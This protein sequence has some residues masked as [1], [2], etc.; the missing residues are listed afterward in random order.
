MARNT[1]IDDCRP[2]QPPCEKSGT[3]PGCS[4]SVNLSGGASDVKSDCEESV[5][6][7]CKK[8]LEDCVKRCQEKILQKLDDDLEDANKEF[9]KNVQKTSSDY[10]RCQKTEKYE[11]K[12]AEVYCTGCPIPD[13][14][15]QSDIGI[16][17]DYMA[18][19]YPN[20]VMPRQPG[21]LTWGQNQIN[22]RG[23]VLGNNRVNKN[24]PDTRDQLTSHYRLSGSS[25]SSLNAQYEGLLDREIKLKD[26][27]EDICEQKA[28][29]VPAILSQD[30]DCTLN[31]KRKANADVMECYADCYRAHYFSCLTRR[32]SC[33]SLDCNGEDAPP[34]G[35]GGGGEEATEVVT[36][37]EGDDT[38]DT[39]QPVEVTITLSA[40]DVPIELVYGKHYLFGNLLWVAGDSSTPVAST[41]STYDEEGGVYTAVSKLEVSKTINMHVGVCAGEIDDIPRVLLDNVVVYDISPTGAV[42]QVDGPT[43]RVLRGTEAQKVNSFAAINEG[44]GRV[45]AY[46][47]IAGVVFEGLDITKYTVFPEMRFEIYET[48]SS[49]LPYESGSVQS[50]EASELLFNVDVVSRRLSLATDTGVRSFDYD[51]LIEVADVTVSD[52]RILTEWPAVVSY[53]GTTFSLFEYGVEQTTGN[54]AAVSAV[55]PLLYRHVDGTNFGFQ[56][57]AYQN[58]P[59]LRILR[60]EDIQGTFVDYATIP[61]V[62]AGTLTALARHRIVT[63]DGASN[64]PVAA[65][66]TVFCDALAAVVRLNTIINNSSGVFTPLA[67]VTYQVT[68]FN[69]ALAV[70][71]EGVIACD[72]DDSLLLLVSNSAQKA[73][74]KWKNNAVVWTTSV[75]FLPAVAGRQQALNIPSYTNRKYAFLDDA[76]S[77]SRV[78]L[79]TGLVTVSAVNSPL[80]GAGNR[81]FYDHRIGAIVYVDDTQAVT[82]LFVD[83]VS[84]GKP[85]VGGVVRDIA[86][87]AG[88]P[89]YKLDTSAI[90][91][92]ELTGY[93]S[94]E[95]IQASA[96]IE[97]L[98]K[99][100]NITTF[101]ADRLS[102]ISKSLDE[103]LVLNEDDAITPFD[104]QRLLE[105]YNNKSATVTYF[106]EDTLGD[107]AT[108]RFSLPDDASQGAVSE[109]FRVG[110]LET[111]AYM[112]NLV[113]QLVFSRQESDERAKVTLPPK[114]LAWTA[115]DI[116]SLSTKYRILK[117]E[118]GADLSLD[119]EAL[120]DEPT[121]YDNTVGLT[122]TGIALAEERVTPRGGPYSVF[123]PSVAPQ[124]RQNSTVYVGVSSV[125]GELTDFT[126]VSDSQNEYVDS[127]G[128]G[129]RRLADEVAWGRLVTPPADTLQCFSTHEEQFLVIKLAK[130]EFTDLIA[131]YY[132]SGYG[133]TR[134]PATNALISDVR[135]NLVLVGDELLQ[136]TYAIIDM[137]GVTVTL[138]G[139]LRFRKGT[140]AYTETH[141]AG[142]RVILYSRDRMLTV[143][144]S[145]TAN[146]PELQDKRITVGD[147]GDSLGN[148][149]RRDV[150][151]NQYYYR[152]PGPY[153]PTRFDNSGDIYIQYDT[154]NN[155]YPDIDQEYFGIDYD[156]TGNGD[157]SDD[158]EIFLLRA[159]YDET[160]FDLLREDT[161]DFSYIVARLSGS[162]VGFSTGGLDEYRGTGSGA[163][164]SSF[165]QSVAAWTPSEPLIGV[166]I[167]LSNYTFERRILVKWPTGDYTQRPTRGLHHA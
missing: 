83:R 26:E 156:T 79:D 92:I 12:F 68:P 118:V 62:F 110:V 75:D 95:L 167:T 63:I 107:A 102:L 162:F 150:K 19:N 71:V 98:L 56:A 81:Q 143:N 109:D 86:R 88:L 165:D 123:G 127:S 54:F 57:L 153:A 8:R 10:Q 114:Y 142:E 146:T 125:L 31:L 96:I 16:L 132:G 29:Q 85:T 23:A 1:T 11:M 33:G 74:L 116:F 147:T 126:D 44:F 58:G 130:P 154:R 50:D 39:N 120:L 99:V 42:V 32:C 112:A 52:P 117:D 55:T 87:R 69:D 159:D 140:D 131:S 49:D 89:S 106:S 163:L 9:S 115:G 35:T 133:S 34:T 141:V 7:E 41:V 103:G 139:L 47:G 80:L 94:T 70:T 134:I 84:N 73:I 128:V 43:V 61:G 65:H 67:L 21:N 46:R 124:Y 105:A 60:V 48:V 90:S 91:G 157:F 148:A 37:S 25:V 119:L 3:G 13:G 76:G 145:A 82:K 78:D 77:L 164:W 137:D 122:G 27:L 53:E 158:C 155:A 5:K 38:A 17:M 28:A 6:D 101:S 138:Y 20:E 15:T 14:S 66:Y 40:Y 151:V 144:H 104:K 59:D 135:T 30:N 18:E 93:R 22:L 161:A 160:T 129:I 97:P 166:L 149:R 113:E 72:Y 108:Q 64:N 45:P 4:K 2:K 51:T 100:Y 24:S 111:N 152:S 121:K 36:P 136:Y